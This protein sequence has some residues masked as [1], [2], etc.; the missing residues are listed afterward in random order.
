[1][2]EQRN[3]EAFN[4]G[5]LSNQRFGV[6]PLN[7]FADLYNQK[8]SGQNI[9]ER[10]AREQVTKTFEEN[11]DEDI[12]LK[13]ARG[14]ELPSEEELLN[15]KKE[16]SKD[17]SEKLRFKEGVDVVEIAPKDEDFYHTTINL[18]ALKAR[19]SA[20]LIHKGTFVRGGK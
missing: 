1:M 13:R 16:D 12:A 3:A 5:N 10:L 8:E 20:E 19:E 2:L 11:F 6:G 14:D 17:F 9:L 18:D 4:S 7:Q 15:Q